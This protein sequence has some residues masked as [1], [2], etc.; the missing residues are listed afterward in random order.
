MPR[1]KRAAVPTETIEKARQRFASL[2]PPTPSSHTVRQAVHQLKT[3][4][5]HARSLGYSFAQ[6]ADQLNSAGIPVAQSTL[7]NYAS[8]SPRPPR[9]SRRKPKPIPGVRKAPAPP[10][11]KTA[12]AAASAP[13]PVKRSSTFTLKPDR[14]KS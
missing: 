4:I 7:R 14:I 9:R 11:A 6:I 12:S 3:E 10:K 5:E 13:E 8:E 1:N 2:P